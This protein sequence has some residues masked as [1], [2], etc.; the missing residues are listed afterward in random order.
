M[1]QLIRV[2]VADRPAAPLVPP[3]QQYFLRENLR[4]RLVSARLA[5]LAREDVGF[6]SDLTAADAWIKQYFD[7]RAKPVQA[8]QATLR[9]L[10]ATPLGAEAPD[11]ARTLEA[12]RVLRA[13]QERQPPQRAPAAGDKR[14][15]P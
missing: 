9:Q 7:L 11:L 13:A 5:L 1:K 14:P 4:L 8:V 12:V 2:E 6:R 10:S 3:A 15:A